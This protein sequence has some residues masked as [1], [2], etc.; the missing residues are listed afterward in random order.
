MDGARW[1][2]SRGLGAFYI[3]AERAPETARS[4][5]KSRQASETS[6]GQR[7]EEPMSLEWETRLYGN[8]RRSFDIKPDGLIKKAISIEDF[9]ESGLSYHMVSYYRPVDVLQGRLRTPSMDESFASHVDTVPNPIPFPRPLS[10]DDQQVLSNCGLPP[11][12]PYPQPDSSTPTVWYPVQME[13]KGHVY[14]VPYGFWP[15]PF[16]TWLGRV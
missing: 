2:A 4:E 16:W 9:G 3:Y 5:L 14:Q 11:L 1:T 12:Y 15:T 7:V 13:W 10:F 8:L 6:N